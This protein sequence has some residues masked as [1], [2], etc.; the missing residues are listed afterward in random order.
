MLTQLDALHCKKAFN[1]LLL[2]AFFIMALPALAA[3]ADAAYSS[4]AHS[5]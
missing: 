4:A 5:L 3:V 2:K 1:F